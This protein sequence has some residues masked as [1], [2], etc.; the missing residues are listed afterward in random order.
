VT[1]GLPRGSARAENR[2]D[3]VGVIV[4][5]ML[6]SRETDAPHPRADQLL[7]AF[8]NFPVLP[9]NVTCSDGPC[10]TR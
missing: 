2:S 4:T 10:C 5:V 7:I 8:S 3:E 9:S 6:R 1:I